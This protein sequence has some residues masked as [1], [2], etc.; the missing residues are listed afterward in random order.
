[1]DVAA[2]YFPG[3][4]VDPTIDKL[5]GPGWTE[6]R[7]LKAAKPRFDG[8]RQPIEPEWGT[9]DE[10][11]PHWMERQID[12]AADHGVTAFLF[13]WYWY[14]GGPFLERPL[15]E[16]YLGAANSGRMKFGLMWANHDWVNVH[17]APLAGAP[18]LLLSGAVD[19]DEFGR[20]CDYVIERFLTRPEYLTVNGAPYFSIYDVASFVRG[21]GTLAR[22]RAALDAFR[23]KAQAAGLPGLN[24]NCVIVGTALLPAEFDLLDPADMIAALGF[25]SATS[26]VWL[27]HFDADSSPFPEVPYERARCEYERGVPNRSMLGVPYYPNVT[28]GWDSSPRC[29]QT[30]GFE[31][32]AYPWVP[33]FAGGTP[34]A[35]ADAL[36]S[37]RDVVSALPGDQMITI[38]AWNEWTEGSYLLPDRTNGLAYLEAVRSTFT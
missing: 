12:L 37:A 8:H 27:H 5:H 38:N 19:E 13:D 17:P 35:F 33:V 9:F 29:V 22:A 2:Y 30:D 15:S 11:D 23:E 34:E 4:H 31:R 3:W 21:F 7:L 18:P 32:A 26:Y 6:W 1:M 25:D 24:L 20:V 16:G 28:M 10:A 36:R 14:D